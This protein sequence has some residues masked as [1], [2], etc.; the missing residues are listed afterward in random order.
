MRISV[1]GTGNVGFTLAAA[2]AKAGHEICLG[3]RNPASDFKNKPSAIAANLPFKEI[4]EAVYWSEVIILA[5]PGHLAL[6]V[7]QSL[8]DVKDKI[9]ID[10]MNAV[11]QKPAHYSNASAAILGSC[12]VEHLAKCFNTTG[13]E[14]LANPI[15]GNTAIDMFVA[16]T[17]A[18]AKA[19][20]TQLAKDIGFGE[21]YDFGGADRFDLM[22]QFAF[23]W[24]NLAIIQKQG[25][26][27]AFKVLHRD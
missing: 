13:F 25:R 15:Y 14:N 4:G 10:A 17:T 5:T 22:E 26:G 2:L 3:V 18:H 1:V 23:S 19:I 6:E 11:S 20:A 8:G 24:I 9:I 27:I 7:A 12:N 16:G 21:V